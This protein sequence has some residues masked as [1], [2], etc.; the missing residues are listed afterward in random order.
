MFVSAPDFR[1]RV[2]RLEGENLQIPK[3]VRGSD[4]GEGKGGAP[5]EPERQSES[6]DA[7]PAPVPEELYLHAE[8]L[9]E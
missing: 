4:H 3:R 7:V 1:H 2:G 9:R 6:S 5:A 8:E